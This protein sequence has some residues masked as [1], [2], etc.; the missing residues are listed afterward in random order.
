[1][2]NRFDQP[3]Q[4]HKKDAE[5]ELTGKEKLEVV[6][7]L[8]GSTSAREGFLETCRKYAALRSI[9]LPDMHEMENYAPLGRGA[10][11]PPQRANLH[12]QIMDTL[13][14]LALQKLTPLQEKVL[15]EMASRETAGRIIK[16]Y[17]LAERHEDEDEENDPHTRKPDDTPGPTYFHSL[18]REH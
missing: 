1:M 10:Y 7:R 18:G 6:L 4:D 17:V 2:K 15:R 13:K 3:P 5:R 11:S 14:H 16:E 12:N 9:A 8:F